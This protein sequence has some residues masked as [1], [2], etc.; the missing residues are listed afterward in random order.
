MTT[1]YRVQG[2]D[3]A[4]HVL[5]GPDD[6]TPAQIEAFAAQTIGKAAQKPAPEPGLPSALPAAKPVATP[7]GPSSGVFGGDDVAS[8]IFPVEAPAPAPA[9]KPSAVPEMRAYEPI[10]A[11]G[12]VTQP[13]TNKQQKEASF[14]EELK[15]GVAGGVEYG[16]PSMA[17]QVKLQG[18]ADS[19]IAKQKSLEL[20]KKIDSGEFKGL[21]DLQNDPVY[22]DLKEKG[23]DVGMVNAYMANKGLPDVSAQLRG[24]VQQD[25]NNM[26]TSADTSIDLL[27]KYA[28]ENQEKYGA[29]VQKFTDINWT[30]PQVAADFTNWM[31][32]NLGSAGVNLAPIVLAGVITKSPGVFALSSSMETAGAV[33]NRMEAVQKKVTDLSP[34][35]QKEQIKQYLAETGDANL[36]IGVVSGTFDMVLGPAAHAAKVA[37]KDLLKAGAIKKAIKELPHDII[38]EASTGALQEVTQISGKKILNE[39][40]KQITMQDVKDI[41]DSAAAEGMGAPAGT[42]VNVGRAALFA[43]AAEK[44]GEK[45]TV[46]QEEQLARSKGFLRPEQQLGITSLRPAVAPAPPEKPV[47]PPVA[48]VTPQAVPEA[49]PPVAEAPTAELARQV[50][51]DE[52]QDYEAMIKELEAQME[53]KPAP[54]AEEPKAEAPKEEAPK[55]EAAAVP[56]TRPT[57]LGESMEDYERINDDAV[58]MTREEFNYE[59]E[60]ES[61]DKELWRAYR[62]DKLSLDEVKARSATTETGSKYFWAKT[63]QELDQE[64]MLAVGAA[65]GQKLKLKQLESSPE[66]AQWRINSMKGNAAQD[67]KSAVSY[68]DN[69][70]AIHIYRVQEALDEGK[71]VPQEVVDAYKLTR[72][73]AP[74]EA[75]TQTLKEWEDQQIELS[76]SVAAKEKESNPEDW[77]PEEKAAYDSGDWKR[78]SKLR[79]YTED[80]ISEY[81]NY[82]DSVKEGQEKHGLSLDDIQALELPAQEAPK[83]KKPAE[84]T[85]GPAA[86]TGVD[87]TTV[88]VK[89]GEPTGGPAVPTGPKEPKAPKAEKV[90]QISYKNGKGVAETGIATEEEAKERLKQYNAPW[91]MK[92][93]SKTVEKKAAA[94]VEAKAPVEISAADR[95]RAAPYVQRFEAGNFSLPSYITGTGTEGRK[96][97]EDQNKQASQDYAQAVKLF[98][99]GPLTAKP[100]TKKQGTLNSEFV[101]DVSPQPIPKSIPAKAPATF[102]AQRKALDAVM[103]KNDMRY[104]LNGTHIEPEKKMMVV[105]DGHR[106]ALLKDANLEGMPE[107]IAGTT[108]I[109]RD[110]KWIPDTR[111][112]DYNRVIPKEGRSEKMTVNAEDLGNYARAVAKA[113]KFLGS[114]FTGMPIT[115]GNITSYVNASYLADMADV[116]RRFGYKTFTME[117]GTKEAESILATSP[118]GKLVQ[119]VMPM[120][121]K[122]ATSI[123]VPYDLTGG[124]KAPA[125]KAE[126][127]VE[128]KVAEAPAEKPTEAAEPEEGAKII[129]FEAS[130]EGLTAAL[131]EVKELDDPRLEALFNPDQKPA[132]PN[133]TEMLD[134][135]EATDVIDGWKA[136]AVGQGESGINANRTVLSL[137]DASGEW[138][139]P[140]EDAGYNV[141][142]FDLTTGQD[143]NNFSAEMLLE[144]FGNDNIWAILA[145]PPCTDYASSGAQY[146]KKKDADGRTEAS[147]ELVRQV[148]RTVELFRPAVW[149]MENPVGRMA[150][151]TGLPP[152]QLTF[153]PNVYGDPYTKKTLLWGAFNNELPMAPVEPTEGSKIAKIS[154]KDKY[155]RSL[156]PEGFAYAFFMANNA[157]GMSAQDRLSREFH[158]IGREYFKNA[159]NQNEEDVRSSIMDSYY[160]GDLETVREIL[161]GKAEPTENSPAYEKALEE[162]RQASNDFAEVQRA[163]RAQEIGDEEFLA[164]REVYDAAMAKFD[165]AYASEQNVVQDY[166][167]ETPEGSTLRYPVAYNLVQDGYKV[168]ALDDPRTYV[169]KEDRPHRTFEKGPLR[170]AMTP[171]KTLLV[172]RNA[173]QI[174]YG[175]SN[176]MVI[177]A[178]MVDQ[179]KRGKGIATKAMQELVANAD[180]HGVTLYIE[181]TPLVNIREKNFGLDKQQLEDFYKK[182]GFEFLEG[183]EKV[184]VREPQWEV[185]GPA[186]KPAAPR[187]GNEP[188]TIEGEF[189]E[190][191][192]A[193][194]HQMLEGPL[195][196]LTETQTKSLEKEYGVDRDTTEF[197]DRVR[198]DVI[199]FVTKGAQAVHGK[200]RSII[201]QLANGVL[202][203]AVVFNPQFVSK[204]YTIAVPQFDV[205]TSQVL[206]DVPQAARAK[207]SDAAQRAYGVIYPAMEK[208]LKENDKFFIVADK[209]SGNTFFFNPDGSYLMDTKTLFGAGIGDFMKGDNE[210]VANRITPA[211]VFDL[212]LRDAKR[213][214]GEARTA[215]DYDFGKVFVLDK[216]HMGSHG[217]YSNTIMHSVWLHEKDAKQRLAALDKP[218]AEDSRYSFGCIN[219]NKETFRNLV[220]NHLS[221]MDGAK[222]FIVPENGSN[223]MD[224]VNGK[225]TYNTD[226]IRQRVEPVTKTT[227]TPVK[228]TTKRERPGETLARTEEE[229]IPLA[230]VSPTEIAQRNAAWADRRIGR[231][232]GEFGYDDGRTQAYAAFINPEDFLKATTIQERAE[233]IRKEAGKLNIKKLAA[234]GQT[235]FLYIQ[236]E[237]RGTE[238]ETWSIKGHEGRHRM[239]ALSAAGVTRVPVV[240]IMYEGTHRKPD[241]YKPKPGATELAGQ[242]FDNHVQSGEGL[243]INVSNLIP[244]SEEYKEQLKDAFG[245]SG[246]AGEFLFNVDRKLPPGRSP[247]LAAAAQ[248]VREGTMTAAEYDEMVNFYK[249][250]RKYEEPLKPATREEVY[251]ALDSAKREKISPD[252]PN[253]TKVGLRLD[254][255]AFNRRGVYVVSIHQKGTKS[256]PGKVIGYDSVAL[257]N[258]VTFGLGRE[259]E[260]LKIAAGAAKDALQT[261]EGDYNKVTVE[262][263]TKLAKEA[264]NDPA[265]V[266][267]GI[268]PTRHS[269]FYDRET[270]EPV[271]SAEQVL[272][273]GNMVLGKNVTYGNKADYLFNTHDEFMAKMDQYDEYLKTRQKVDR[274]EMIKSF[275]KLKAR[276][277]VLI[278]KIIKGG[279]TLTLQQELTQVSELAKELREA[280]KDSKPERR[281]AGNFDTDARV[282]LDAEVITQ[283]VYDVIQAA[284]TKFPAL[285]EGLQFSTVKEEDKGTIGQFLPI[286]RIVRLYKKTAGTSD[287]VTVEHELTHSLEQMM[288]AGARNAVITAWEND[289]KAAMKKYTAEKGFQDHE[290]YFKAVMRFMQ[291]PTL[292]T[293]RDA[294]A[295]LPN[296]EMYQ[297]LNP[298]EYWA[299]NAQKLMGR[300]LGSSWDRFVNIVKR[301][302][303]GLKKVLGFDNK[304]VV[305]KIFADIVSGDMK[306]L[307]KSSLVNYVAN[308][309][310]IPL[311]NLNYKGGPAP[312]AQWTS[313]YDGK[314][315]TVIYYMADKQIDTKRV[316]QEIEKASGQISET[317]DAY[318]KEELYHGRTAKQIGDFLDK[319]LIAILEEMKSK[320]ITISEVDKYLQNR[321]AE[322]R[323]IQNA[324]VN[325]AMPGTDATNSGSGIAT[326]AAQ[327]YL[328][329]LT[330]DQQRDFGSIAAKIDAIVHGTQD[331]LVN[332]GLEKQDTIDKWNDTYKHYVPLHR[333]EDELDFKHHGQGVGSGYDVRGKFSKRSAGSTK[334]VVDIFANIALQR[335]RA[336]IRAEKNRI[337]QAMYGLAISSPNP[338]FWL[339]I[340]P[341]AIKSKKKLLGELVGM[342]L[343]P[344][345]A[346]NLFMEPKVATF[347]KATG[348]V[349]YQVN[350]S[351]RGSANVLSCRVNGED[352]FV[353]FNTRDPR[354][355]RMVQAMKNLDAQQLGFVLGAVGQTTRWLASVNTQYNPVFGAWNFA[356]DVGGAAFNLESTQLAG[357][358]NEVRKHIFPALYGI[359]GQLRGHKSAVHN[360]YSNLFDEFQTEGGQT[361][362]KEQFSKGLNKASIVEREMKKLDRG[363]ARKAAAA[364]FNWLSDYNDAME[365]AVRLAAYKVAIDQGLSKQ[366][367]ASIAKNLTVNFNRKG[368]A[369]PVFQVLYAFFSASIGG[370]VRIAQTLNTPAGKKIIAGGIMLGVIQAIALMLAGFD[371]DEPPDFVKDKNFVIPTFNGTGYINIP[372]P[373][374]YNVFPGF[375]RLTTEY[376]LGQMGLIS[377][378]KSAGSKVGSALALILDSFNPLGSGGFLQMIAPTALDPFAAIK[379]NKDAFG[380]P[381]YKE[382]RATNPTPGYTRSRENSTAISQALAEFLNWATS[383]A[384]TKY[385]KGW[386]SP[387]ADEIDYLV[388]QVTGGTGREII[389]GAE[390]VSSW[391]TGE[392]IQPHRKPIIGKIYG[393]TD[394]P[395]AISAKFYDNVTEMAKHE[396]EIKNLSKHHES[397]TEY[398]A[399]HPDWRFMGRANYLENQVSA[400]NA[401][402]KALRERGGREEQ[403]KRL[404]ERK[405]AMMKKFNDDIKKAQVTAAQ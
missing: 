20:M 188:Y 294:Q 105:T 136:E 351:L 141:V 154:G 308:S 345:E 260:A 204:P 316:I 272:Q 397:A 19:F 282:A 343:S 367:A 205:R 70:K 202:S 224:F 137:F 62:A 342:G 293:F 318:M 402:K 173:V 228:E 309:R 234:E 187:L 368:A 264:F 48:E 85:A 108:V 356:R 28:R 152:A 317:W 296:Y 231:L 17:Q 25:F 24:K 33:Q 233:E 347:D 95:E 75:P 179:E 32:Y 158:G 59:H 7:P 63:P 315:D 30:D 405:T 119:V 117:L 96:V 104:Y 273:I 292:D 265:W 288:D 198:K 267:I 319:D 358:Q 364:V 352:R 73:A 192:E 186:E 248:M 399:D 354:A 268:D 39:E 332:S 50:L 80:E 381:I 142:T 366:K 51:P 254:I 333:S 216:S 177:E 107:P 82:L 134:E 150:K 98:L 230:N 61:Y 195:S 274:E 18:S 89:P 175:D 46:S 53:G 171:Q 277:G 357:K 129:P 218:G 312:L 127:K 36:L 166:A 359:Y 285:L 138:A 324:S 329:N 321:H 178:I 376:V 194:Q 382:D 336:I 349:Q 393:D 146:W 135:D 269:Y 259:T 257:V 193:Q 383:P 74:A 111:F 391:F 380:R 348:L 87:T 290:D 79:G 386:A 235:P 113:G 126:P 212:G 157:E 246:T 314:M 71:P 182:F 307:N 174:G 303:E 132:K 401:Q 99:E 13:F 58:K 5:E 403:I 156:T 15:K 304:Y 229:N 122:A 400:I 31:G 125:K 311:E 84:P 355:M 67:V 396:N 270:T 250:I 162:S 334:D 68:Y 97:A 93:T 52:S 57:G 286:D 2:P 350:P 375:G 201:R 90:W 112:P 23:Q 65:K 394:S 128:K 404:D 133:P 83:E 331:I 185:L 398:K 320:K 27:N 242:V 280:I 283:E 239:A 91:T 199:D 44:P 378:A 94:P 365:N 11:F 22:S 120:R 362:F 326:A 196:K 183:T 47:T 300:R 110:D 56:P 258:N 390:Y 3:G 116:F 388:G 172:D 55:E 217:P 361:G 42:A 328:A 190:V 389:K 373:L 153:N 88:T 38:E 14:W 214:E 211:G 271:V 145:A 29:R 121:S 81:Q 279:A 341:A 12:P 346:D 167:V 238:F 298:S 155:T 176:E 149:A 215:G 123:F 241:R 372:Y 275:A 159:T 45:P 395:G 207:M 327:T 49:A 281:T 369:S 41:I 160:D 340:N 222:I 256:G 289:L 180:E 139:K 330:A 106:M 291:R 223:V 225:A 10:N 40:P 236:Q 191:A 322:E 208:T 276:R 384:G 335:E 240:L 323:N 363:N 371:D 170:I 100:P 147:N 114:E 370:T 253:G 86:P 249:P 226:I 213:S 109:G 34:A 77:T 169:D 295:L 299:V 278:A 387:T 227:K 237:G 26:S 163:Y 131:N 360:Y 54:K 6:A 266:Q 247:Q 255:P 8:Q 251:D 9:R 344:A 151:L 64:K 43:P 301:L 164:G 261:I 69:L 306:R 284:Y 103:A 206:A 385:T 143:I 16:L 144:E 181:P 379:T 168:L 313:P 263:A 232:I 339:P 209:R 305:H 243:D 78:F 310:N 197:L 200:I 66:F 297:Y 337:S 37:A 148:L 262:E 302:F 374:G 72:P 35:Q 325:P 165:E 184:M 130:A 220:T 102:D 76:N 101:Q 118:D 377:G 203:V 353:F 189:T 161:Q 21:A 252:I 115:D 4:I 392:E 140:W 124:Q 210:I 1:R 221:Q 60:G 92:I 338:G 287:P 245:K 244:I 219:V